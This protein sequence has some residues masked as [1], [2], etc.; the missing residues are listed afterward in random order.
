M[1]NR[2]VLHRATHDAE[3]AT[4]SSGRELPKSR[5]LDDEASAHIYAVSAHVRF[6]ELG[7]A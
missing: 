2:E 1:S 5:S 3:A 4:T 7:V 6:G